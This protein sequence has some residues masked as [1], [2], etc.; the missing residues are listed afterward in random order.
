MSALIG[1]TTGGLCLSQRSPSVEKRTEIERTRG[2]AALIRAAIRRL[3]LL[4]GASLL[5]QH[6]K[7]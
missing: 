4:L 5:E 6:P 7:T 1:A 3:G 2:I